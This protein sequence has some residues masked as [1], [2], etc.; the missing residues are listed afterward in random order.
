MEKA[1]VLDVGSIFEEDRHGSFRLKPNDWGFEGKYDESFSEKGVWFWLLYS[2]PLSSFHRKFR[3]HGHASSADEAR[4][5]LL[6]AI[7]FRMKTVEAYQ[8][9][10]PKSYNE[11]W[12]DEYQDHIVC[13]YC[14]DAV[15]GVTTEAHEMFPQDFDYRDGEGT[16]LFCTDCDKRFSVTLSVSYAFSTSPIEEDPNPKESDK[17]QEEQ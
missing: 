14:G 15:E 13:P 17:V 16:E 8:K 9:L 4:N 12:S 3:I 5:A 10:P 7:A 2:K 11:D 1:F 6:E